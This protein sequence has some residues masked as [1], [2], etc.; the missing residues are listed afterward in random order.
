MSWQT[1]GRAPAGIPCGFL[2]QKVKEG[3]G[4]DQRAQPSGLNIPLYGCNIDGQ[5][6]CFPHTDAKPQGYRACGAG[7]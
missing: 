5:C 3:M 4:P 6:L 1:G 7:K 2:A